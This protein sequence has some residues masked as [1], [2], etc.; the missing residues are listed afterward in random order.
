MKF[1]SKYGASG[2]DNVI[3]DPMGTGL[4]REAAGKK[5]TLA[6]EDLEFDSKFD[7]ADD[8]D[9]DDDLE[10]GDD[11]LDQFDDDIEDMDFSDLDLDDFADELN[12]DDLDDV[13]GGNGKSRSKS[14]KRASD[15]DYDEEVDDNAFYNDEFKD[16]DNYTTISD[17]DDDLDT[18]IENEDGGFYDDYDRY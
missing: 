11:L 15:D 17:F 13:F 16:F 12:D 6:E 1:E 8:D 10:V 9:D 2:F 7:D 14:K 3:G 18:Y 4:C 5:K